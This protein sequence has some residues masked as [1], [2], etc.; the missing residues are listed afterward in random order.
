MHKDQI[1]NIDRERAKEIIAKESISSLSNVG[2][3]E[4]SEAQQGL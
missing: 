1:M 4:L 2:W 3:A